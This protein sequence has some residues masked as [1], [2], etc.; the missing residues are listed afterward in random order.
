MRTMRVN[1]ASLKP[2]WHALVDAGKAIE[3]GAMK[4]SADGI[5]FVVTPKKPREPKSVEISLDD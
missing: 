2:S 4:A 3:A 5:L 1:G